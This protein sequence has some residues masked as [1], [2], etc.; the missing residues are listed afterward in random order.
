[1]FRQQVGLIDCNN[2]FVSCERLF[3]PDLRTKPVVVLS[4][5]DGCVVARSQEIKDK[6]IP[7]G[8][9]YFQVKDILSEIGAVA[10]SSH[11]ALYRDIS[12]RVFNVVKQRLGSI[13]QY[14]IDECFFLV[15][16]DQ[17]QVVA[18]ELRTLV[19][20]EVGIPVSVGIGQ[21]RTQAKYAS[22]LAKKSGGV[23]VVS[24]ADWAE[25]Q[26]QIPLGEI[27]GVGSARTRAFTERGL[28]TV[29]DYLNLPRA[30][31]RQLF[32]VEGERLWSELKGESSTVLSR[33]HE[34][35]KSLMS[36]RSFANETTNKTT[37]LEALRYHLHEIV[38]DLHDMQ[39]VA[40]S[41]RVLAYPSRFSDYVL[42]GMSVE[43]VLPV[44]SNNLFV[45]EKYILAAVEKHWRP[46]VPYK[47]AGIVAN[48]KPNV[49]QTDTLF[50][51]QSEAK[52][53]GLTQTLLQ[54]NRR[55]GR[56]AIRLGAVSTKKMLWQSRTDALSPDYTTSWKCLC[57]VKA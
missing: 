27:W 8:V 55:Q 37:V 25:R 47:K 29:G 53:N 45:L 24:K 32:G 3:R 39:A 20:Q 9:P 41:I 49:G 2:F 50:P 52:T 31:A 1:M 38:A 56:G 6:G 54:I 12:R 28:R 36:T 7:M 23:K 44:P 51:S 11:F 10:F 13:E 21:S 14:S 4:S 17:A 22:K 5:N 57:S 48:I 33:A 30:L 35:Q 43:I 18:E 16:P 26:T 34:P 46:G 42:Q 19:Y 40:T 15:E